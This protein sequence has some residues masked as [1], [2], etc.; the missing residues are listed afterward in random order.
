MLVTVRTYPVPARKGFE[1]SCTGGVTSDG[2]WI[3]LFPVP[4][5]FLDD[6]KRFKKYQ[7][8]DV[9]VKS[10]RGDP[11]PESHN[12]N[13]EKIAIGPSVPASSARRAR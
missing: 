3:R 12:L 6:D 8:I 11:R 13:I 5:R 9:D 4:Y 1:V 7:W 10:A 2:K